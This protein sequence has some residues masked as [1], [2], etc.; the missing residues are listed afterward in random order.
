M[1]RVNE[2]GKREGGERM[3]EKR[4]GEECSKKRECV[5]EI[6]KRRVRNNRERKIE[7]REKYERVIKMNSEK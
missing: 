4:R 7:K 3:N 6:I 5:I 1:E 2:E